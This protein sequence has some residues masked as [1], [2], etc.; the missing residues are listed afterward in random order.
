M[1]GNLIKLGELCLFLLYVSGDDDRF[2]A[3]WDFCPWDCFFHENELFDFV[4]S[5]CCLGAESGVFCH[6]FP[7][8]H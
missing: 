7:S 1:A 6:I 3:V 8:F 4:F 5:A 2:F